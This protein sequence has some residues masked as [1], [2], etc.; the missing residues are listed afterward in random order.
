M[1]FTRKVLKEE[2]DSN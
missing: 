1:Y 2:Q